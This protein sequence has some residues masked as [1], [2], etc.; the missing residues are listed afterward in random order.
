MLPGP[1]AQ[2]FIVWIGLVGRHADDVKEIVPVEIP[3]HMHQ[4]P[5][6]KAPEREHPGRN[7]PVIDWRLPARKPRLRLVRIVSFILGEPEG[8][9][10]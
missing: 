7:P 8:I 9:G 6:H 1:E 5:G 4:P 2:A 10:Y 3:P